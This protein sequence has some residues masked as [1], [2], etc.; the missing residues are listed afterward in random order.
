[1]QRSSIAT[2]SFDVFLGHPGLSLN[3]NKTCKRMELKTKQVAL[4]LASYRLFLVLAQETSRIP[5]Y[6]P[7]YHEERRVELLDGVWRTTR[8]GT[9]EDP[10]VNFDSMN[11]SF[12]TAQVKMR[13]V[14]NVPSCVD[15][16][17]PG[18]LGYRGVT[19][20]ERKF[21]F[22]LSESGARLQ[23]LGCSF[24]CRVWVNGE[25]VGDHL[26]GGYVPFTLDIPPQDST[27]NSIIVLA[28]NRW[29]A[30]TAP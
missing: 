25:E 26:A 3:T 24:Y 14:A 20:Y 8:L 21:N 4:I 11:P 5:N 10:P 19:F 27:E 12:D 18:Y 2:S 7:R 17:L 15:S 30:T 13:E 6:W 23:F 9:I 16:E 28:D 29:N 22:N 1:M